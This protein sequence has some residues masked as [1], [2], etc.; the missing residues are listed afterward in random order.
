MDLIL[1]NKVALVTGGSDG[2]GKAAATSLAAE[3]AK[4]VICARR[5][6]VLDKAADAIRGATGGEVMAV[7]TDVTSPD[8]LKPTFPISTL[9][10][11]YRR[12]QAEGGYNHDLAKRGRALQGVALSSMRFHPTARGHEDDEDGQEGCSTTANASLV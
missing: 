4:V 5:P 10:G 8:Q 3:G 1:K 6:D 7:P 12:R 2:I 11:G 9:Q